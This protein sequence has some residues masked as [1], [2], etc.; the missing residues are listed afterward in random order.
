MSVASKE[1]MLARRP[2]KR[3]FVITRS[4]YPGAGAHVGKW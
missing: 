1:A 3:P 4:T 2:G